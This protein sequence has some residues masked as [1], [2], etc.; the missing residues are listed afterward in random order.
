MRTHTHTNFS[1]HYSASFLLS[2]SHLSVHLSYLSASLDPERQHSHSHTKHWLS[3]VKRFLL[4]QKYLIHQSAITLQPCIQN[5]SHDSDTGS[6]SHVFTLK[7][8]CTVCVCLLNTAAGIM[9]FKASSLSHCFTLHNYLSR[10]PRNCGKKGYYL[11]LFKQLKC[12]LMIL[13]L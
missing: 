1:S 3:T 4:C 5:R 13:D 7:S 11:L 6:R 8:K 10:F 2:L 9:L 12:M